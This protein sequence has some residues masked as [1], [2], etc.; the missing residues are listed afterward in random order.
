MQLTSWARHSKISLVILSFVLLLALSAFCAEPSTSL[1]HRVL[2]VYNRAD[3]DS[4]SVAKYYA[5]QRGIPSQNLCSISP[6]ETVRLSWKEYE[7]SVRTPIQKCL[8][9][10]GPKDILYIVFTYNTPYRVEDPAR[11]K[12]GSSNPTPTFAIDQYIADIWDQYSKQI[13]VPSPTIAH[14]YYDDAW[15]KLNKYKP[16]ESLADYREHD[17]SLLIYSVWRLDAPTPKLAKG[18]VDMAIEAERNGLTGQA[19]FDRRW[20]LIS[21]DDTGYGAGDWDLHQAATFAKDAGFAVTEDTHPEEFGTPPAPLCPHAAMYSGWYSLNHYNNAFT[22]QTGAIGFHLDSLSALDPRG[23]LNWSS[24][25]IKKGIT[26]T[27]GAIDEPFLLGLVRPGGTFRDLFQGA[28]VG[29][30]FLRNTRYLK[31]MILYIGDPLYRPFPGG[32]G[33]FK[34]KA[35]S[36]AK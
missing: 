22:W 13:T 17:N 21:I 25:A 1:N 19:C 8:T 6:I 24:N 30:A 11:K 33:E 31:W 14:P 35:Q 28:N 9:A 26:V 16:F 32:V 5:R 18:M 7:K 12:P 20:E 3:G 23:G 4:K 10:L 36:A 27:T 2:V 34:S 15:S 29:D